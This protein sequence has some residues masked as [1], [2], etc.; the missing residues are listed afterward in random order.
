MSIRTAGRV[1]P[2][3][4]QNMQ[5]I[6][7]AIKIRNP[8]YILKFLLIKVFSLFQIDIIDNRIIRRV[9]EA[10]GIVKSLAQ[11]DTEV[12][13]GEHVLYTNHKYKY[14]IKKTHLDENKVEIKV[15][16]SIATK[17]QDYLLW[18]FDSTDK[19][20]E[21]VNHAK[22]I[23]LSVEKYS[24]FLHDLMEKNPNNFAKE[25]KRMLSFFSPDSFLDSYLSPYGI[26]PTN[27][28]ISSVTPRSS[29]RGIPPPML[30]KRAHS[31][32]GNTSNLQTTS[33]IVSH[34][35]SPQTSPPTRTPS[36]NYPYSPRHRVGSFNIVIDPNSP[37]TQNQ[38]PTLRR[39]E[40]YDQYGRYLPASPKI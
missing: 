12:K 26:S 6:S 40:S 18:S 21:F 22:K 25:Q 29:P 38:D 9:D 8:L 4:M 24:R 27:T 33:P 11:I 37:L 23:S 3:I 5:P 17:Q 35:K 14:E 30:T 36:L 20:I 39:G 16:S 28:T 10:S 1:L 31:H 15:Y 32:P 7:A 2:A 19:Y 34:L 13:S